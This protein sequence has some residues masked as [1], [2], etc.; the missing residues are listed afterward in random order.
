MTEEKKTRFVYNIVSTTGFLIGVRKDIFEKENEPLKLDIYN[1]LV[2][3]K[4]SR[5]I[6]NLCYSRNR[7]I[8]WYSTINRKRRDSFGYLS[9][10]EFPANEL[11]ELEKDGV[12]IYSQNLDLRDYLFELNKA[13]NARINDCREFYPDWIEWDYIRGFFIMPDGTVQGG[14]KNALDIF[15]KNV[16][17]YPY[18]VYCNWKPEEAGNIF[19][20]DKKFVEI[21]YRQNGEEFTDLGKVSD[22]GASSKK[23]IG[24]FIEESGKTVFVVDCENSDPFRLYT[25]I[26]GLPKDTRAKISKIIMYNDINASN[27]WEL[28]K[29]QLE[30]PVEEILTERIRPQK[31]LVDISLAAGT[32]REFYR[33]EVDSF[34]LVSSDSDY[35][36]LI[37]SIPE[38]NFLVMAERE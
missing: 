31:S 26:N 38:A 12:K 14:P 8:L 27:A 15:W 9:I 16:S 34:V 28:L 30:I 21:L 22:A 13:I 17:L 4:R 32:C 20:N 10:P 19:Y 36:G 2:Q 29:H 35:W 11:D 7:I 25:A 18:Q 37:K 5:I 24:D 6:R 33:N 23:A 3:D 1:R